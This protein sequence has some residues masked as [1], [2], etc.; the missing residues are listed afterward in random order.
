[1]ES[2]EC[3]EVKVDVGVLKQQVQTLTLL[4]SKMDNVIDKL[5]DQ[6]D[7]H[8]AKVYTDMD[9]RRLETEADIKEIH[10]RIDIVL[11]KLQ[12]SEL[13]IMDEIKSLRTDMIAQ[14]A[15][16]NKSVLELLEWKWIV[17]GAILALIYLISGEKTDIVTKLL[18]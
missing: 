18:H 6:H 9:S 4:C 16:Q 5:L 1:M 2:K 7:R 8:I 10:E 14:H 3:L 13:R 15:N 12:I 11:D 17:V